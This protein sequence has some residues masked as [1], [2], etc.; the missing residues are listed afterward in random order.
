MIKQDHLALRLARLK[1]SEEL[2]QKEE[3]LIFLFSKG[4]AGKFI[5]RM[6]SAPGKLDRWFRW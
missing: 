2:E 1:S 6:Y 5:S 4:G 3:A